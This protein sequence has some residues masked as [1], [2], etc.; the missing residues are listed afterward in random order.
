VEA[1]L[2]EM[3][4]RMEQGKFK[5]F[6]TMYDWFQEYRLYHRKDGKLVKL[7]DDLMSATRYAVM[8]LRYADI[9]KSKW[10]KKGQLG[11]DVAIV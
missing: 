10:H 11:P 6:N 9:E 7:K 4:T 3:L 1:G 2:M 5:V 8:S